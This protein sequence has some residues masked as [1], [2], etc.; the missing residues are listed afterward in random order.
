M[1]ITTYE[2]RHYHDLPPTRTVTHN[3]TGVNVYSAAHHDKSGTT[4]EENETV[5]LDLIV[6]SSSGAENKSS[7]QLNGDSRTKSEVSGTHCVDVVD[8]PILDLE[9]GSNEQRSGKLDPTKESDAVHHDTIDC[10]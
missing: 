6:H 2:G 10:S 3:T 7:E 5:C 1:V 9:S 8:A 4:V